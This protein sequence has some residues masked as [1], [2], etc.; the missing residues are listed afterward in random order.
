MWFIKP[1]EL[2]F[3]DK[4]GPAY[5]AE[6]LASPQ[7]QAK[8]ILR[9]VADTRRGATLNNLERPIKVWYQISQHRKF[10]SIYFFVLY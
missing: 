4:N 1:D 6:N 7:L 5:R 3:I 10:L 8:S 2:G 9:S